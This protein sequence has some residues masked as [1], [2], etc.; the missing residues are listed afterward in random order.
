MF[1]WGA[2]KP[3]LV[4]WKRDKVSKDEGVRRL[5]E[6]FLGGMETHLGFGHRRAVRSLE[7]FLGGMETPVE[8]AAEEAYRVT[9][10][11]SLVEWKR[12]P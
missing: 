8:D 4:E 11:P 5:L 9:L 6:T 10:K 1:R 7:T 12:P 2:L 3:S